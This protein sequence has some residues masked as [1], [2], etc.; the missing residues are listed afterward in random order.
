MSFC[1]IFENIESK[2]LNEILVKK[3]QISAK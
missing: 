2:K 3:K 1:P